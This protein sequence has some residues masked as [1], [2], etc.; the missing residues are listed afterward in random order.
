LPA[1]AISAHAAR[2]YFIWACAVSNLRETGWPDHNPDIFPAEIPADPARADPAGRVEP[3]GCRTEDTDRGLHDYLLRWSLGPDRLIVEVLPHQTPYAM[4]ASTFMARYRPG[5]A[6]PV[7]RLPRTGAELD[8]VA[9]LLWQ[10]TPARHGAHLAARALASWWRLAD[11]QALQ[12]RHP[13]AGLAAATER[14]ACYWSG[15]GGGGYGD[16]ARLWQVPEADLR[17]AGTHLQRLL[18]LTQDQPW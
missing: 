7:T 3:A 10:H 13:T 17:K 11:P 1:R 16:A 5:G 9:H 18:K 4:N 12:E 8:P 15:V 6:E 14:S 2:R